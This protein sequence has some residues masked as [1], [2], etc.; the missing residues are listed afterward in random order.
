MFPPLPCTWS[1]CVCACVA[2]VKWWRKS[3]YSAFRGDEIPPHRTPRRPAHS[4]LF[5]LMFEKF[6]VQIPIETFEMRFRCWDPFYA[7]GHRDFVVR[8][9][10]NRTFWGE[11][12][13]NNLIVVVGDRESFMSVQIRLKLREREK[14]TEAITSRTAQEPL[15]V[16]QGSISNIP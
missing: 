15:Q 11:I 3:T 5:Y 16:T 13:F 7:V 2:C 10:R 12:Y 8:C 9:Q 1:V 14:I 4:F 6:E